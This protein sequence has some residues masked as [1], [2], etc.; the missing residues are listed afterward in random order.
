MANRDN[1]AMT[2]R[3][4]DWP[5][6]APLSFE[7]AMA[8]VN[9]PL[10]KVYKDVALSCAAP[11]LW[12]HPSDKPRQILH[13]GTLTVVRTPSRVFGITAAHVLEQYREDAREGEIRLQFG[14]YPVAGLQIIDSSELR[15]LSTCEV[16]EE[17]IRALK[18]EPAP[19]PPQ[20]PTEGRG[21]LLAGWPAG[22][23]KMDEYQGEWNPFTAITTARRLLQR[24]SLF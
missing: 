13:N 1:Q 22:S 21:V 2:S 10:A 9:G 16:G 11:I 14:E 6:D 5:E 18:I 3:P 19:W 17:I 23:R 20:S 12:F 4:K 7:K 15:D 24:K 8:L